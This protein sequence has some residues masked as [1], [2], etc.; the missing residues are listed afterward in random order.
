MTEFNPKSTALLLVDIQNGFSH[1]TFWGP[2]R[3]NPQF[4]ENVSRLLS[5][6]R[7]QPEAYIIHVAHHS[8]NPESALH[9]TSIV[10]DEPGIAFMP[11]VAP[12][13]SESIITKNVN[14]AFIGTD[15]ENMLRSRNIRTLIIAGLTTDH[16]VSTTTRMAGNL[17]VCDVKGE[18]GELEK[19]RI[20]F[21]GT[22]QPH[23][24][25][26]NGMPKLFRLS[27]LKV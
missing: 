11:Y 6:I 24:K 23:T 13:E 3:S 20:I 16:C 21:W 27:T 4:E 9:P 25:E 8:I 17:G 19:G 26:E 22:R 2:T 14:S 10:N 18:S 5:I 12:N 15:L 1:P 7:A